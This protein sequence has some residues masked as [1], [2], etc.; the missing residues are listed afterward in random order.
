M[1]GLAW[2]L[3]VVTKCAPCYSI[4]SNGRLDVG[5]QEIPDAQERSSLA[6]QNVLLGAMCCVGAEAQ[7]IGHP[8]C[9]SITASIS[10][11]SAMVSASAATTYW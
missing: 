1:P 6:G 8:P 7:P 3:D 9:D 10:C 2:S 4:S 5:A 11:I